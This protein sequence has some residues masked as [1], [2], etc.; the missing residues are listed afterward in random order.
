MILAAVRYLLGNTSASDRS[1]V[2]AEIV[3]IVSQGAEGLSV[4]Q[5]DPFDYDAPGVAPP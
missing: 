3:E 1:D 5:S 4:D 2:M